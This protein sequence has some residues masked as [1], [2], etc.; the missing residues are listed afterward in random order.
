MS[1]IRRMDHFTIVTDKPEQTKTFYGALGLHPG[2]RPNFQVP[3][4]WL[5]ADEGK[6]ILHVI[7]VKQMPNPVRG[8]LDHMAFR[9]ENLG[10]V[11][12]H[13]DTSRSARG[14]SSASTPTASRSRW[15]SIPR[16]PAPPR[17]RMPAR[18]PRPRGAWRRPNQVIRLPRNRGRCPMGVKLGGNLILRSARRARLEGWA[19]HEI[20]RKVV[21]RNTLSVAD[22]SRRGPPGRSSG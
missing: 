21:C 12:A 20:A 18:C 9:G 7:E 6:P 1:F 2:D 4:Y 16:R 22:P 14:S 17:S 13:L 11:L 15:I 3:G 8:G 5:Y 10:G 19:T